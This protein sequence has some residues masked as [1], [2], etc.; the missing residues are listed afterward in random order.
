MKLK[1]VWTVPNVLSLMR[2]AMVPVFMVLYLQ[3]EARPSL[4]YG[5]IGV[6][7]LSGLTDLFDGVIA[8]RCNQISEIGKI[9][10]PAAD[11]LTQ[12]AVMICLAMR[13]PR[14]WPLVA[15]GFVKE[16]LQTIGAALL[17]FK[18]KAPVQG[19]RWCGK[20]STFVFYTVMA[21]FVVFPPLPQT[22]LLF[23]WNMPMWLFV[24]LASL[25]AAT[26]LVAFSQYTHIYIRLVKESKEMDA[27][28][29]ADARKG[30]IS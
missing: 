9:L 30:A 5:A 4:L 14:L 17:L 20:V 29:K 13:L 3:S 11:K 2:I 22:P 19:S 8:R 24:L 28:S 16:L 23:E 15:I 25:V 1:W 26:M 12:I 21:L 10:D 27:S 6:L 7:V 18:R